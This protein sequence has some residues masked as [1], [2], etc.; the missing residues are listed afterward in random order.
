MKLLNS[1]FTVVEVQD[2]NHYRIALHPEH[3]IYQAHFPGHP[4]TPGVCIVKMLTELKGVKLVEI[5]NLKFVTPLSPV[6]DPE[7][8]VSFDKVQEDGDVVRL[9][10][11]IVDGDKVYTKFSL[12]GK[13]A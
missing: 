2:A 8:S 13:H 10:G 1:M 6:E 11:S 9:R 7:V 3:I 5:K 4:I 12:I